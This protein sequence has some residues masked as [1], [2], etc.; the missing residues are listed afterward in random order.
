MAVQKMQAAVQKTPIKQITQPRY[1]S[2]NR[3]TEPDTPPTVPA[4]HRTGRS[5]KLPGGLCLSIERPHLLDRGAQIAESKYCRPQARPFRLGFPRKVPLFQFAR[6]L[7]SRSD[8]DAVSTVR[9]PGYPRSNSIRTET[10]LSRQRLYEQ[11]EMV[12]RE[13]AKVVTLGAG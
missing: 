3:R 11:K 6:L 8:H 2:H 10:L 7:H 12:I 13:E 4:V 5:A 9:F 1:S